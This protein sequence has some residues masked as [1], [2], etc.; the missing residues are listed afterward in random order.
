MLR[1]RRVMTIGDQLTV[2]LRGNRCGHFFLCVLNECVASRHCLSTCLSSFSPVDFHHLIPSVVICRCGPLSLV[3][4]FVSG[5][6]CVASRFLFVFGWYLVQTAICQ[7][8][9]D[10]TATLA[11]CLAS[12]NGRIMNARPAAATATSRYWFTTLGM[13]RCWGFGPFS[14]QR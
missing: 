11:H 3:V 14:S 10:D 2:V 8:S 4:F 1:P 13:C 5:N 6:F 9:P 12:L 7:L